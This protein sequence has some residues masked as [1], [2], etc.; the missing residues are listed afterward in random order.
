M[1]L[2]IGRTRFNHRSA[3]HCDTIKR[4]EHIDHHQ[5]VEIRSPF[6]PGCATDRKDR[7]APMTNCTVPTSM[8]AISSSRQPC[9]SCA[10]P[11]FFNVRGSHAV[12]D[13]ESVMHLWNELK[14]H[15]RRQRKSEDSCP[16]VCRVHVKHDVV[17]QSSCHEDEGRRDQRLASFRCGA[18]Q[19]PPR[20]SLTPASPTSHPRWRSIGQGARHVRRV[21][22]S[23]KHLRPTRN[24]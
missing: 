4:Q 18:A 15:Y 3:H 2:L 21:S 19:G 7:D 1:D 24:P 22:D 11:I 16:G 12:I 13:E 6:G 23:D 8:S 10:P 17:P 9:G 14:R 5:S 20:S